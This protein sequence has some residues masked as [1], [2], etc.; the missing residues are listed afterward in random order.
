[1]T[2]PDDDA[3]PSEPITRWKA[4]M[5]AAR[6][7]AGRARSMATQ[8][9]QRSRLVDLGFKI[10]ERDRDAAGTLLGSALAL[11]FFLFL[12][13][14]TLALLGVAG[15]LGLYT[16][17]NSISATAGVS[18]SMARE[19]DSAF[20]QGTVTPWL[21]LGL[22]LFGMASSGR[23][24]TR[25][26]AIAS[27]VCWHQPGRQRTPMRAVGIVVGVVVGMSLITT[28]VNRIRESAGLAI[29]SVSLGLIAVA[30]LVLWTPL[31][32]ALPQRT[33]DPGSALP[34]AVL[35]TSLLTGIHAISQFYLPSRLDNAS[36][37]YGAVGVAIVILGWFFILGRGVAVAFAAN[38]VIYE[39]YGSVSRIVFG[40]PVIRQLP[41]RIP[42]LRRIFELDQD[43][44][45]PPRSQEDS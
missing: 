27:G 29:A 18:G 23:S 20:E 36:S 16:E 24:L 9:R 26:L 39:D 12:V 42:T 38:A 13:P 25:A 5:G 14:L 21:A 40:L 32:L 8:L 31:F 11:R 44:S 35:V 22:G 30:Y 15:L 34:G 4:S 7:H 37:I 2:T 6:T 33:R 19:I 1:M 17:A 3:T 10:H 43:C 45:V 41:R 28:V